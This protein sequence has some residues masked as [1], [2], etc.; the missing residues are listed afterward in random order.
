MGIE[1]KKITWRK[2]REKQK[3]LLLCFILT[4]FLY[5]YPQGDQQEKEYFNVS[6]MR[7]RMSYHISNNLPELFNGYLATKIGQ[8][9][10][11]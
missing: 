9:I 8:G 6:C 11:S 10:L 3:F 4:L 7:L 2:Q 5:L 1:N